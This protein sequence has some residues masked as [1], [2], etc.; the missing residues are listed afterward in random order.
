MKKEKLENGFAAELLEGVKEELKGMTIQFSPKIY[1]A[2][3]MGVDALT[4]R[5]TD[6]FNEDLKRIIKKRLDEINHCVAGCSSPFQYAD[7]AE[8][9]EHLNAIEGILGIKEEEDG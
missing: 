2:I 9:Q 3:D 5:D 4:F 6:D 1:E 8:V 7:I